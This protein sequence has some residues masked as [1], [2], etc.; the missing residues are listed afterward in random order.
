MEQ[1][2]EVTQAEIDYEIACAK[3]Y[4]EEIGEGMARTRAERR[5][6]LREKDEEHLRFL[7]DNAHLRMEENKKK[8]KGVAVAQPTL[9]EIRER[10]EARK[11]AEKK[12]EED[13]R[14]RRTAEAIAAYNADHPT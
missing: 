7:R 5:A 10:E 4:G 6:E 9:E 3:M 8:A 2:I 11:A 1:Q 12:A 13:D 14:A